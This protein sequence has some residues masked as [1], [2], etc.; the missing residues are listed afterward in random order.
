MKFP[1]SVLDLSPISAGSSGTQALRNTVDLARHADTLGFHRYWLAEHHN[2]P[3]VVSTA[4]EVMVAHVAAAT[5][6][7]RVGSGGIMLPNH[8]PLHVAETFRVLEALHPGRIDLGLGRAPGSDTLTALAMRGSRERLQADDFSEKLEEL[9]AFGSGR[10]PEGHPFRAVHAM[11]EDV[12]LPPVFLLGSS[13][14]SARLAGR[15]GL[16]Y[17]F[18]HH[19]SPGWLEAAARGYRESLRV[20]VKGHLIITIS[21]VCAQT[22]EEAARLASSLL[23]AGVRRAQGRFAPLPSV[24]EAAAHPYTARERAMVEELR[25]QHFIGS[26][27]TVRREIEAMAEATGADEIMV[28]TMIHGHEERVRSYELLARTWEQSGLH[29]RPGAAAEQELRELD[30]LHPWETLATAG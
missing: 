24:E 18:A 7:L 25:E 5:R 26:P 17:A 20:G 22:D 21:V 19:F 30:R 1:L 12:A 16:G 11:P 27:E 9:L 3:S 14:F 15:M 8:S 29:G 4:P 13:D 10:F 23:L 2:I 28:S 6:R